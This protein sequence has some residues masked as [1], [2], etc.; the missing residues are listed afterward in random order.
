MGIRLDRIEAAVVACVGAG[1]ASVLTLWGRSEYPTRNAQPTVTAII[2]RGPL[3]GPSE[4]QTIDAPTVLVW[5]LDSVESGRRI[6]IGASGARW[7]VDT[8]TADVETERDRL[9]ARFGT[10]E[11]AEYLPGVTITADSTDGIRFDAL[12]VPGLLHHPV[13]LGPSLLA[14]DTTVEAETNDQVG[15]V[16]VE[17]QAYAIGGGSSAMQ[18]LAN[19]NAAQNMTI[20]L[21][22]REALGIVWLGTTEPTDLTSLAGA[23]WKSRAS[24]RWTLSA[25]SH[26]A[27]LG[28]VLD[29]MGTAV[30]SVVT[31]YDAE[32]PITFD[33]E[34]VEP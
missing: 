10:A 31:V 6:G 26:V 24:C 20:P 9:L 30:G 2:A 15:K 17:L 14:V 5:S 11:G 3:L 27:H 32:D 23:K 4:I 16:V 28:N 18:I 13:A 34:I 1:D 25:R 22:L 19:V 8:Q 29:T 7:T 21:D 33:L 12:G